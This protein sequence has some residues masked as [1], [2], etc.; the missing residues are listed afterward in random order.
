MTGFV[1][2]VRADLAAGGRGLS[3]EFAALRFLRLG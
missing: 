1:G 3:G 2:D